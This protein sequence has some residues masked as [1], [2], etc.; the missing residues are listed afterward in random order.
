MI[1]PYRGDPYEIKDIPLAGDLGQI[2]FNVSNCLKLHVLASGLGIG[3]LLVSSSGGRAF[4]QLVIMSI[5]GVLV[6]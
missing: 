3:L 6:Y 2:L 5:V 1:V 4:P